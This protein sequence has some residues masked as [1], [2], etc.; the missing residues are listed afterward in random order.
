MTFT[1]QAI[2]NDFTK[3]IKEAYKR[4][5]IAD[6]ADPDYKIKLGT[7][8]YFLWLSEDSGMIM[9]TNDKEILYELTDESTTKLNDIM[10]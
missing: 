4:D 3:A 1:E 8:S 10:K 6:V 5:G 2:I 7:D 9:F